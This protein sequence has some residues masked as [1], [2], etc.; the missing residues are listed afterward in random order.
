MDREIPPPRTPSP[1]PSDLELRRKQR[2]E[3]KLRRHARLAQ[4]LDKG[5][6]YWPLDAILD[7][8]IVE[9]MRGKLRHRSREYL[10]K[11][12]GHEEPT[13]E[14]E[15][16]LDGAIEMLREYNE[17]AGQEP[18]R[19]KRWAGQA[20]GGNGDR[21]NWVELETALGKL[22][23]LASQP[24]YQTGAP[25]L[26][27]NDEEIPSSG[28]WIGLVRLDCHLVVV[29]RTGATLWAA[30]GANLLVED[31]E[32]KR[33]LEQSLGCEVQTK[34]FAHQQGQDHC[35]SSAIVIA[36][37]MLRQAKRG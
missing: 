24:T 30:D 9:K 31:P 22:R 14:R 1:T 32:L 16:K 13:W 28:D 12:T 37:E 19:L 36:L 2:R 17:R 7:H 25:I 5:V 29:C 15:S 3:R 33:E 6:K 34:Y 23:A 26:N 8:R 35:A 11:W 21:G 27:L 4:K 18:S 20:N 10:L